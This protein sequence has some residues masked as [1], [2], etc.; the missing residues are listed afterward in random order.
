MYGVWA[1]V[2]HAGVPGWHC[3]CNTNI[4]QLRHPFQYKLS[5]WFPL[6]LQQ[7]LKV[8]VGK[9]HKE[10]IP[11][12]DGLIDEITA[13]EAVKTCDLTKHNDGLKEVEEPFS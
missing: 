5:P 11:Q 4:F 3:M 6:K 13:D 12:L 10:N 9:T 7:G 8:H 2:R 1:R